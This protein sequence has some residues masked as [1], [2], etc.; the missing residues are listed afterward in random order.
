MR[1]AQIENGVVVNV[2]EVDGRP[3]AW[4]K[5]WVETVDASPGWIFAEGAFSAPPAPGP[6]VRD[7][8]SRREFCLNLARFGIL[9]PADALAA[10]KGEWPAVMVDF[11]AYL[12][13]AQALDAQIEWAAAAEIERRNPIVLTLGSWLGLSETT[14]NALF[15]TAATIQA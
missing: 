11:L 14:E 10:A 4:A 13:A 3:P 2:I 7:V 9:Q 12:D 6:L 15:T 1:L 8:V 5:G